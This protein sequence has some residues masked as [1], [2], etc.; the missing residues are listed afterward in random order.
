M[1]QLVF[2]SSPYSHP[3]P[4]VKVQRT[5]DVAK[6]VAKLMHHDIFGLS[7]VLYGLSIIQHGMELPDDWQFWAKYCHE[8]MKACQKVYIIA[9]EGWA[10]SV[11]V[12]GEIEEAIK[13]NKEVFVIEFDPDIST[14]INIL[15]EIRS[16]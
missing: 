9:M 14:P 3:N 13:Q 4:E 5:K 7:P 2:I 16:F 15:R 10:E 1:S 12:Q 6:M 8:Y 11:G